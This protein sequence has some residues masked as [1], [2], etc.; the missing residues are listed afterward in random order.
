MNIFR[1]SLAN[2]HRARIVKPGVIRILDPHPPIAAQR[3]EWLATEF[4]VK[5][6]ESTRSNNSMPGLRL[7]PR[8][9]MSAPQIFLFDLSVFL[10]PEVFPD[11]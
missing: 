10:A 7:R 4:P 11:G 1:I 2:H 6:C 5:N 9:R 8:H 3:L